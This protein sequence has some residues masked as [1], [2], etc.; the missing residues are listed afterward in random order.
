MWSRPKSSAAIGAICCI[1]LLSCHE[2][3]T[4]NSGLN[5]DL[6]ADSLETFAGQGE[7]TQ[8]KRAAG[9]SALRYEYCDDPIG[10]N[11]LTTKGFIVAVYMVWLCPWLRLISHETNIQN[12]QDRHI[13]IIVT[14][15][16]QASEHQ[17]ASIWV[18]FYFETVSQW[19]NKIALASNADL[20][21]QL[22]HIDWILQK[23]SILKCDSN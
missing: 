19:N 2:L 14:L 13:H 9:W 6:I 11:I 3:V 22:G 20:S 17:P 10:Q 21:T 8:A 7:F 18:Q 23:R 4:A 1:C 15:F 16:L 5:C 12:S